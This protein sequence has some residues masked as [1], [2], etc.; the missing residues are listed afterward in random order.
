MGGQGRQRHVLLGRA[1]LVA[2]TTG[3]HDD[4]HE[5]ER[6]DRQGDGGGAPEGGA[7][8]SPPGGDRRLGRARR[9]PRTG[10]DPGGEVGACGGEEGLW[11][12]VADQ[13]LEIEAQIRGAGI[14][15]ARRSRH[16]AHDHRAQGRRDL[17]VAHARIRSRALEHLGDHRIGGVAGEGRL[18]REHLEQARPQGVDVGADVDR[19]LAPRLLR[20]HVG[21]RAER[22][23]GA[24]EPRL[25]VGGAREPEV[26][27]LGHP[28]RGRV[29]GEQD[30]RRLD[31]AV[32]EPRDRDRLQPARAVAGQRHRL[33]DPQA[34]AAAARMKS[35]R[36]RRRRTRAPGTG[37]LRDRPHRSRR[38]RWGDG[39][40]RPPAPRA[41]SAPHSWDRC[42]GGDRG[43]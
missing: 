43:P 24:R 30:V 27:E 32:D 21:G 4:D 20:G 28:A 34:A 42:R 9:A 38:R 3:E 26:A 5:A 15:L 33:L 22:G 2:R 8:T 40:W 1:G 7:R 10:E 35:R 19:A 13:P 31:V 6:A 29:G 17:A 12:L 23:S 18:A 41:G 39:R 37:D 25:G 16:R 11:Q 14:A 36:R